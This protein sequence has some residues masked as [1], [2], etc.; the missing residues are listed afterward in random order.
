MKKIRY[1][2][3]FI[4]TQEKWLNQMAQ[5][6]YRLVRTGMLCYEF[7]A[8][9]PNSYVYCVD[10]VA[11]KS[12]AELT[13]YQL[14]L[15]EFGYRVIS[16]N[17]NINW[18]MGKLRWRPYGEKS[19]KLAT[20]PGNYNKELLIVEKVYD[21]KPFELHTTAEDKLSYYKVQRNA[22]LSLFLLTMMLFLCLCIKTAHL[23][24]FACVIFVIACLLASPII[25][26]QRKCKQSQK[27]SL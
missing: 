22:Y 12:Y 23:T 10:F 26:F 25:L 13:S 18:S 19:G 2:A 27:Q 11:H 9:I 8:C 15:Q 6:G 20:S 17:T 21:Q 5:K 1:F 7:E 14:F 16:K 4:E 24:I 3:G